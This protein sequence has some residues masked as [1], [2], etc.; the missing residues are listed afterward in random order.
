[1]YTVIVID[2]I[3]IS[4][5]DNMLL[6]VKINV[7]CYPTQKYWPILY[8]PDIIPDINIEHVFAVLYI[9]DG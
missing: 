5:N 2:L 9:W 8:Y 4:L 3:N 6:N 1:M 7:C